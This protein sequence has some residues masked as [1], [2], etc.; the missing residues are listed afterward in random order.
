MHAL[1]AKSRYGNFHG[2]AVKREFGEAISTMLENWI[3]VKDVLRE[4]SSH[5]A[6]TNPLVQ[7]AGLVLNSA[8]PRKTI[9]EHLLNCLVAKRGET[10]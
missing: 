2:Y 7:G 5:H 10:R 1:L 9:P 6:T 4:M 3:W 8:L